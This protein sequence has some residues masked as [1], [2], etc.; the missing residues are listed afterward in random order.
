MAYIIRDGKSEYAIIYSGQK[1]QAE[2]FACGEFRDLAYAVT[3]VKLPV[4]CEEEPVKARKVIAIG[5]T[6]R[7]KNF[8]EK[9]EFKNKD[10]YVIGGA[11]EDLI[12]CG[13][14]DRGTIYGVYE[15]FERYF[16]VR[17]FAEDCT[18]IPER[19]D[20]GFYG[21]V[22]FDEPCFDMRNYYSFQITGW[23]NNQ[24]FRTRCRINNEFEHI[25]EKYGGDAPWYHGGDPTHNSLRYVPVEKYLNK[26]DAAHYHPEFYWY[27]LGETMDVCLSNGITEDGKQDKS[28]AE[29]AVSA[30]IDTF[31]EA[32]KSSPDKKYFMF[33]M[34]DLGVG[35]PCRKCAESAKKYKRSGLFIRFINLVADGV[36]E[37]MAQNNIEREVNFVIFAYNYTQEAPV[38]KVG[39]KYYPLDSTVIPRD[40]VYIRIATL[41]VNEYYSY[42]DERQFKFYRE[43][44][45]AWL[46]VTDKLMSWTY[47]G[48][49]RTV[50]F[51]WYCP[52]MNALEENI[53]Y[54][55]RLKMPYV[56]FQGNYGEKNDWQSIMYTYVASKLLWNPDLNAEDLQNEFIDGYFGAAAGTVRNVKDI[57]DGIFSQAAR[58]NKYFSLSYYNSVNVLDAENYPVSMLE[59]AICIVKE[60]LTAADRRGDKDIAFRL[61]RVYL[62]LEFMVC[63][64]YDAY[65]KSGRAERLS[66]FVAA[67]EKF[68]EG[69]ENELVRTR[70]SNLKFLFTFSD[71]VAA[72]TGNFG[73]SGGKKTRPSAERAGNRY[74]ICYE[75]LNSDNYCESIELVCSSDG[76]KTFEPVLKVCGDNVNYRVFSPQICFIGGKLRFFYTQSK[77]LTE[78]G[79][80]EFND[81]I[82]GV[83]E[84]DFPDPADFKGYT[85]ARRICDGALESKPIVLQN[86]EILL[87]A[88]IWSMQYSVSLSDNGGEN[89]RRHYTSDRPEN[90]RRFSDLQ[91][92]EWKDGSQW[93]L[94]CNDRGVLGFCVSDNGGKNHY[95]IDSLAIP[96]YGTRFVARR[97]SEKYAVILNNN[98][99]E[100]SF[101]TACF[102]EDKGLNCNY[103]ELEEGIGIGE[104]GRILDFL[105][106]TPEIAFSAVIGDGN[107]P[108]VFVSDDTFTVIYDRGGRLYVATLPCDPLAATAGGAKTTEL[109]I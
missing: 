20:I 76:L 77:I 43:L 13:G 66:G 10:G 78:G 48:I 19:K 52:T 30:A 108:D 51:A 22:I 33:G 25:E 38:K 98:S 84:I 1:N 9:Y 101:L 59:K 97:V 69:D 80:T 26:E 31:T 8:I 4:I 53:R 90:E 68:L 2:I 81:G 100:D 60:G 67:L 46:S 7:G 54:F 16:G 50:P 62:M 74:F 18:R 21:E 57:L 56:M 63:F 89:Y 41:E 45:P 85:Q 103:G 104:G 39:G 28:L 86:G 93:Q 70:L 87:P 23:N 102:I 95:P 105:P 82:F 5:R 65:Y 92:I 96:N 106:Y 40:N 91:V 64:N 27:Y 88:D 79:K 94:Q 75:N 17:F 3:G 15:Y 24:L 83:W 14:N 29:S 109:N 34:S 37:R 6:A 99:R 61:Q 55:K 44:Y 12:I 35:C 72:V 47:H 32:I 58:N 49:Y 36:K 107:N 71:R 73:L 11:G 42:N